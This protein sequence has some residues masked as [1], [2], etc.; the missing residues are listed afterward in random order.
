MTS[1]IDRRFS[2]EAAGQELLDDAERLR[3]AD[4]A[5]LRAGWPGDISLIQALDA[6]AGQLERTYTFIADDGSTTT[7][8]L[9]EIRSR[10]AARAGRL[11]ALGLEPG[12]RVAVVVPDPQNFVSAFLATM[13]AGLIPV[14]L[15]PPLSLGKLDAYRD[16]MTTVMSQA[17]VRAILSAEWLSAV[18]EPLL[19]RVPTLEKVID[20]ETLPETEPVAA[21]EPLPSDVAFLQYTSGSTALPKGVMVTNASLTAN[22]RMFLCDCGGTD[23]TQDIGVSW[24]PMYHDMGLIAFVLAPLYIQTS[25]VFLSPLRFL[26][27]PTTW[28]DALHDYRGT[29]TSAPNFAYGLVA[30][31]STDEQLAAW[32]LSCVRAF[33]CGAEPIREATM[34]RFADRLAPAGLRTEAIIPCYGMAEATV[35][36]SFSRRDIP[37]VIDRIDPVAAQAADGA[38]VPSDAPDALAI[39]GCG[40]T[41]TRHRI[42]IVDA[43]GTELP[44]RGIGEIQFSGPSLANGYWNNPDATAAAFDND[45]WL[46]TGDVGYLADGELFVIGRIKDLLIINGRNYDPSQVEWAAAELAG[47]RAGNVVAFTRPGAD[48][49]ELVVVLESRNPGEDLAA[50]VRKVVRRATQLTVADVVVLGPGQLP[51]TSSGKLQRSATRAHYLADSLTAQVAPTRAVTS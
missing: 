1:T 37:P 43:S 14:P 26:K 24:L 12:D 20:L 9:D 16:A 8:P 46:H 6:C 27:S 38:A 50:E 31:R 28:I 29:V 36:I 34:T 11:L 51:K 7:V 49:E 30:S 5:V 10:A 40:R 19:E 39:Y 21:A 15:Y 45:G 25:V 18:Y 32:D 42:R 2:N 41:G 13:W 47:V 23:P 22:C 44:E 4:E 48:T 3:L 17:G 33:G 35:G